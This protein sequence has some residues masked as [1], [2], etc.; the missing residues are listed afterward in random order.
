[1]S[2][3]P[4][5]PLARS[6]ALALA[7]LVSWAARA[8]AAQPLHVFI[9]SEYLDPEVVRDFERLHD[10]KVTL[11]LYEDAESMMAKLQ[12]GGDS[13]Y[14]VVVPPDHMVTPLVKLGLLSKL[15]LD[16]IQNA[17]LLEK[18][19][20]GLPFDPRNE[21]TLAYQWGTMGLLYRKD[22]AK[23]SPDSWAAILDPAHAYG[24]FVLIDS[25][26]DAI[27]LALKYRGKSLN[28]V[29]VGPLKEARDL[30]TAAKRRS[31]ALEGSV[32]GKNRVSG[33]SA[34]L[35]VVYSGEAARGMAEDAGL[36]YVIPREGSQIWVDNLA[37]PARAPHR[38]LAEVFINHL[39]D[40]KVAARNAAY[41]RFATPNRAARAHLKPEDL[42]NPAIYPPEELMGKLEFLEDLGG[43]T[44][45][46]DQVWTHVKAN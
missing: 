20:L 17:S 31:V 13:Q 4:G 37:I 7:V 11:D 21:H 25:M 42:A 8:H 9:W 26:R 14:D 3:L 18:R 43:K 34:A 19:F 36:A 27:G 39:L 24:P 5:L 22:P 12:A 33:K 10:A 2:F 16:R 28:C 32:G 38:D 44:R 40:G 45:L 23:K 41:T 35:A 6:L 30:L 29:E 46:F 15:R 1:M